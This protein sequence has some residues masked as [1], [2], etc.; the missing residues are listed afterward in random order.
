VGI[1][2]PA[3]DSVNT[4]CHWRIYVNHSSADTS[5]QLSSAHF[6][7]ATMTGRNGK[8]LVRVLHEQTLR[9][10]NSKLP[11]SYLGSRARVWGQK[12]AGPPSDI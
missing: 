12:L 8:W 4:G 2:C 7:P 3:L 9:G 10:S 11:Y 5:A 1:V 6:T